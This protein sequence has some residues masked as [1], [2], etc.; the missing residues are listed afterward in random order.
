MKRSLGAFA[1]LILLAAASTA[2]AQRSQMI[3]RP[4]PPPG[5]VVASDVEGWL[6]LMPGTARDATLRVRND[7]NETLILSVRAM[8]LAG[9]EAPR[10]LNVS[11][12]PAGLTLAPGENATV[13]VNLSARSDAPLNATVNVMA[14]LVRES[15]SQMRDARI[16]VRIGPA[17]ATCPPP[18]ETMPGGAIAF[19]P[20]SR[21]PGGGDVFGQP[22]GAA[23][24]GNSTR[25]TPAPPVDDPALD[26]PGPGALVAGAALGVAALARRRARAAGVLV[27]LV[28]LVPGAVA[29]GERTFAV[30]GVTREGDD[31]LITMM[32]TS[33]TARYAIVTLVDAQGR[34]LAPEIERGSW[35]YREQVTLRF[36]NVNATEAELRIHYQRDNVEID[37]RIPLRLPPLPM[38][39]LEVAAV[40][41]T[42]QG[43]VT[44][45]ISNVGDGP[46]TNATAHLE[47]AAGTRLGTPIAIAL[48]TLA[49]GARSTLA[50]QLPRSLGSVRLV[51]SHDH[52]TRTFIL[53]LP[54]SN[55]AA[56]LE[57]VQASADDDGTAEFGIAHLGGE[58]LDELIAHLETP[59]GRRIGEP[60]ALYLGRLVAGGYARASFAVPDDT[61]EVAL[62]LAHANGTRTFNVT[63]SEGSAAAGESEVTLETELPSREG[64]VGSTASYAIELTNEGDEALVDL[65]VD[66]LPE[67]YA[68]T[69]SVGGSA[70]RAVVVPEGETR[71]V[72]LAVAIPH[73]ASRDAGTTLD[74]DVVASV[75]GAEAAKATLS[76]AVK[77]AAR[78]ELAGQNWFTTIEPGASTTVRVNVRNTGSALTRDIE[79]AIS[80]PAG[81]RVT[82]SPSTIE[83]LAPDASRD[84]DLSIEPPADAGAGRYVLDVS[85]SGADANARARSLSVEIAKEETSRIGWLVGAGLAGLVATLLIVK[86]RRR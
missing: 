59:E 85:A 19:G 63:L 67:G 79:M 69:F 73:S 16:P 53:D 42:P 44:I 8:E 24:R 80:A 7:G 75:T 51:L 84:V 14:M 54:A 60:A 45:T 2:A 83:S 61:T 25:A 37:E 82:F 70:A 10:H 65:R 22:V 15:P 27:A 4:T 5:L 38:A 74:F 66:G 3:Q 9:P 29:T 50:F 57:L 31:A 78:L 56:R 86:L 34:L 21:S 41:T 58:A 11:A 30:T 68:A 13:L 17:C 76:L 1:L 40:A 20:G 46:A 32:P 48:P 35:Y 81:W 39:D 64:Q 18:D 52:D 62:V 55:D 33:G 71:T 47:D 36:P 77:G 28:A 26:T 23:P 49:A 43:E 6:D 72:T 12:T